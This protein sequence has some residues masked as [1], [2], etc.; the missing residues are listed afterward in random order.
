MLKP[1]AS[2]F[3]RAR[4]SFVRVASAVGLA[5]IV[6]AK[7]IHSQGCVGNAIVCEN[8]QGGT[9]ASVWDIS[10]AGD[11]TLQGFATAASVNKG[12]TVH[13]K[14]DTTAASY[15]VDL[16]RLGY[17]GGMGARWVATLGTVAGQNQP[18][19]LTVGATGLI[20]CGNWA[21]SAA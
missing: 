6:T 18:N 16:Y 15:R 9:A 19:C 17:Y 10:G 4:N 20:D 7:L 8:Q 2:A 3:N 5:A 14:V 21:E 11:G 1:L 12:E 13:F